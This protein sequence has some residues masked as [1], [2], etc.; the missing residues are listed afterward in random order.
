M[1]KKL[2]SSQKEELL[3]YMRQLQEHDAKDG[4]NNKLTHRKQT[5]K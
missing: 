3:K 5:H 4:I 1:L 2:N